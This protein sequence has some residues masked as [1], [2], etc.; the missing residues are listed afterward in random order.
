MRHFVTQRMQA[1]ALFWILGALVISAAWWGSASAEDA[2]PPPFTPPI[3]KVFK[4]AKDWL[5]ASNLPPF[6][7]DTD[8]KLHLR[9]YYFNRTNPNDSINEAWA[10]GGWI[11]Y[12]SGWLFETFAMGASLYGSAELY[13]PATATAR[14]SSSPVR[15]ATTFRPRRGAR[16][17][18]RSMRSSRVTATGRAAVH[19]LERQPDDAEHVRGRDARGQGGL[20][21]VPRGLP[22]E[23]QAQELR[24]VHRH[25]RAGRRAGKATT[26]RPD[27]GP[28]DPMEGLRFESAT[29]SASTPS[30]RSTSRART[31]SR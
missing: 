20:G 13:A 25:V 14:C 17:A 22:V 30:T 8:L 6:I 24:R 27:R 29:I 21:P 16:C 15:K 23:D 28:A 10:F 19:Q 3:E 7:R 12:Q 4:E 18:T 9:S 5:H 11:T 26:H 2:P 31:S 1:W